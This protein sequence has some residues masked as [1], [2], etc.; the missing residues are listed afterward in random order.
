[1][2]VVHLPNGCVVQLER[3]AQQR[4]LDNVRD[5]LRLLRPNIISSLREF[6]ANLG[7]PPSIAEA[8]EYLDVSLDEL[9]KRGLWSQLLAESGLRQPLEDPDHRR[10][11]KGLRRLC[12]IDNADQIRRLLRYLEGIP[13][14]G[15]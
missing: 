8:V 10:L 7:R 2:A 4:V 9:L 3:V 13:S 5:S 15:E 6:G 1:M 12:H 14:L 11:A